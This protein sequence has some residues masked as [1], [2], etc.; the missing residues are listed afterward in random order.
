MVKL[1]WIDVCEL[2]GR[3]VQRVVDRPA[4]LVPDDEVDDEGGRHDCKRNGRRGDQRETGA[5]AHGSRSAYPTPRTV[6]IRRG[7]PPSSVLRRRY[8][9]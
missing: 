8:P 3:R 2:I 4:Q 1:L 7:L 6:W 9:M 5:K